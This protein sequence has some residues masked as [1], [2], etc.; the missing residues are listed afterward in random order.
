[1][2][3]MTV[4][5]LFGFQIQGGG[6]FVVLELPCW[7]KCQKNQLYNCINELLANDVLLI[8]KILLD[9]EEAF[10]PKELEISRASQILTIDRQILVLS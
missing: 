9:N 8:S 4:E 2:M 7:K 5:P 10:W 3:L 1:M 6:I